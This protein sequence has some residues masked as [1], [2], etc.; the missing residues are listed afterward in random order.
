MDVGSE[1]YRRF[2]NGD[3]RAMA[4]LITEYRDGLILYLHTI[5]DNI[6]LAEELAEETFVKLG[7]RRSKDKGNGSFKTWLYTIARN[8]AIDCLRRQSKNAYRR[9]LPNPRRH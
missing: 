2:L 5:V 8:M 6:S 9:Q 7:T 3:K 4:E 1:A